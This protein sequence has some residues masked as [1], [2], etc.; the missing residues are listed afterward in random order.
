MVKGRLKHSMCKR[1][2]KVDLQPVWTVQRWVICFVS[3]LLKR[4]CVCEVHL[5][6][7]ITIK[8]DKE[9]NI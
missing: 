1:K 9:K 3:K 7:I 2:E 8:S 6:V 5:Y 4:L